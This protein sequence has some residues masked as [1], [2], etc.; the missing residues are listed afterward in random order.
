MVDPGLQSRCSAHK[1][2]VSNL[3]KGKLRTPANAMVV[4]NPRSR[5][6]IPSLSISVTTPRKKVCEAF[7]TNPNG[8]YTVNSSFASGLDSFHGLYNVMPVPI[9]VEMAGV[10]QTD[11]TSQKVPRAMRKA[12]VDWS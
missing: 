9:V 5:L 10:Y 6:P 2:W 7:R 8:N 12:T 4:G 11:A 3:V 1:P